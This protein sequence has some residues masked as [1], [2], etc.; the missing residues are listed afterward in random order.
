MKRHTDHVP[1]VASPSCGLFLAV[2]ACAPSLH[3]LNQSD[4]GASGMPSRVT[5]HICVLDQRATWKR[6]RTQILTREINFKEWR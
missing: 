5:M 6:R 2:P 1:V 4:W 3:K